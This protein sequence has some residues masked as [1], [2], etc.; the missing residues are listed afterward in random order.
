MREF[1]P[2]GWKQPGGE[3]LGA[4][5][6]QAG[7]RQDHGQD[8]PGTDAAQVRR[9]TRFSGAQHVMCADNAGNAHT[10]HN[11]HNVDSVDKGEVAWRVATC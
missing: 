1:V 3:G 6:I 5:R 4:Q 10:A 8:R 2:R 11:A 7:A 9:G